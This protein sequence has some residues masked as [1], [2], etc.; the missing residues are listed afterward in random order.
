[1]KNDEH[2]IEDIEYCKN[3]I[4]VQKTTL[5][6]NATVSL[7]F[8]CVSAGSINLIMHGNSSLLFSLLSI[9]G[10]YG[11]FKHFSYV[12]DGRKINSALL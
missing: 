1:M 11:G 12:Q 8:S 4:S 9:I 6:S 10:F 3:M 2:K 5:V 7:I